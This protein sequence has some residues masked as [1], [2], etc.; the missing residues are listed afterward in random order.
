MG[1][2]CAG[3]VPP[4]LSAALLHV[5][6]QKLEAVTITLSPLFTGPLGL[7]RFQVVSRIYMTGPWQNSPF[8]HNQKFGAGLPRH[9]PALLE[10]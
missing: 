6:S 8:A 10:N 7:S 9:E 3:S 5:G 2:C 1:R 4:G